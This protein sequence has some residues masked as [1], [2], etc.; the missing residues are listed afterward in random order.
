MEILKHIQDHGNKQQKVISQLLESRKKTAVYGAGV[1][2]YVLL[3]YLTARGIVVEGVY[4]DNKYIKNRQFC[5]YEVLPLEDHVDSLITDYNL[6]IG[7]ADY[8]KA[9][10]HLAEMGITNCL[11]VD[12]P[13]FLNIPDDF[14]DISFIEK[15]VERF[16]DAYNEFDDTLSKDTYIAAINTKV[17]SDVSFI[18]PFVRPDH[19]Y[20]SNELFDISDREVLLDVGGFDGD[21]ISDFYRIVAGKFKRIISL[22][23]YEA[24]YQKLVKRVKE[25][26]LSNVDLLK[27]GA[28]NEKTRLSFILTDEN[29]DNR[30]SRKDTEGDTHI[31][32]DTIDSILSSMDPCEISLIKMDING[33]EYRA[34][35]G[36]AATIKQYRPKIAVKLHV[37]E[38]FYRLPL[39]LKSIAPDIKLFLRQRNYMSMMLVLY[40][41]FK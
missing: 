12:V 10:M 38:D 4:V 25:L 5:E 31:D 2:A 3:K 33:A 30:I 32:V 14:M 39:L 6:I 34:L 11:V 21:S 27:V 28:W 7:I 18:K 35:Q 29:I 36:A 41:C 37:K 23:P 24:N 22:E 17:N 8:P 13:D 15:N 9:I 26:N 16:K 1:F 40:G 20:F 19:L